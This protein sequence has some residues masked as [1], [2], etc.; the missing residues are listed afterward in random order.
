[1]FE[2]FFNYPF[3][4]FERGHFVLLSAWPRWILA[5]AIAGAAV[6]LGVL[7]WRRRKTAAPRLRGG[8]GLV[9]W[10][11]HTAVLALLLILLWEPALAVSELRAQ[12]NIIAVLI[13]DSRSMA[14]T[15]AGTDAP[16]GHRL[17]REQAAVAALQHGVLDGLKQRFQVRVYKVGRKLSPISDLTR[18]QPDEPSTQ[19]SEGLRQ[20]TEDTQDLPI[21]AVVLLSDGSENP[22][23]D[24]A[25]G[26]IDPE[27][28]DALRNR[29]L[30]VHTVGFGRESEDHDI[31]MD[32][33]NLASRV[34]AGARMVA[35]VRFHQHGFAGQTALLTVRDGSKVLAGREVTLPRD[36]I[37][38]A[39]SVF[40]NAGDPGAKSFAFA[41]TPL[42]S[43]TN[44]SN[45]AL[46][47]MV[48]VSGDT[49][50]VL[51]VEGEPRWEFKFIRRAIEDDPHLQMASMLRTTENKIYRQGLTDPTE[52]ADGFPVRPED[53]FVYSGIVIGSVE[54]GYFTPAQQ[55]LLREFVDRRGGG[56]LFLGGRFSLAD[57]GWGSSGATDL[58]PTFL[59]HT[60]GTFHRDPAFPLL[61]PAGLD[62]P[63]TRLAD[64]PQDNEAR[65][66]K[67][68]YLADFQDAGSPKP[69]ATVLLEMS[70]LHRKLP[71]LVTEPYG[72]GRTAVLATAG[73]WRW[74][75]N[76]AAGDASHDQFW[77]Q[78]MRWV[79]A[80]A[81]GPVV[82]SVPSQTL[83]DEGQV[84]L[85]AT[86]RDKQYAPVEDA[87][88]AAR[89]V[90][91]D[92][93]ATLVDLAA[94]PGQPGSFQVDWTADK[95]G[96][97]AMEVTAERAGQ[98]L[99][100]DIVTLERQDGVAENFHTQQN[101]TL[102][103]QLSAATGGRYWRPQDL[104][105]LPRDISYSEAGISLRDTK[106]LWNMPALF[107][108]LLSMICGQWLLR[109]KWGVV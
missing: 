65:W 30:P 53:L 77:R 95:P 42:P 64:A 91:P 74:Q 11:L 88:V 94:V 5:L 109:R 61:T 18:V 105:S 56:I 52:L 102:L 55:E 68:P 98:E 25:Q 85:S 36:G 17:T 54:A 106:P 67:L 8:R 14:Q 93:V 97:Y 58:V 3:A 19:L 16:T 66:K 27:T 89:V 34:L 107:L 90:G 47:R 87:T 101:R 79:A 82:A 86:V 76:M 48:N 6:L 22:R 31:E 23:G 2:V 12:Q 84:R 72:R 81:P 13:D 39:E 71:M 15:D 83:L 38:S 45:N 75:M 29:L 1:M 21:G 28:L 37:V 46:S 10:F 20:F 4:A 108:L 43:E 60:L 62:S 9:L 103:E 92:G 104:S 100:R 33:V 63:V 80:D 57:G 40:F 44:A 59:P 78:L 26:G 73:S 69:G 41:L 50:R 49:R 51:Y 96:Q 70:D 35:T 99:G 7:F 24:D 32:A